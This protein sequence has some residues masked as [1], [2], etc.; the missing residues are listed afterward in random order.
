MSNPSL[1]QQKKN[2][3]KLEKHLLFILAALLALFLMGLGLFSLMRTEEKVEKEV[4]GFE[5]KEAKKEPHAPTLIP[6][7]YGRGE[8]YSDEIHIEPDI[9]LYYHYRKPLQLNQ[10]G[11]TGVW[12][13]ERDRI[14]SLSEDGILSLSF[15]APRLFVELSGQS[16]LPVRIELDTHPAG[17]IWVTE[18]REYEI[19]LNN[20][21][22][23]PQLLT[24]HVPRGISVYL[25]RLTD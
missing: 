12:L 21:K 22:T 15:Q 16:N 13:V 17:E 24:L 11:L 9:A 6:L 3:V 1:R 8:A 20:A 2:N 18:R 23:E 25:F 14:R 5:L 10:I 7:G 19:S 4:R